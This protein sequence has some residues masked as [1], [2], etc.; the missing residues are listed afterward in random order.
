MITM[1]PALKATPRA[2]EAAGECSATCAHAKRRAAAASAQAALALVGVLLSAGR[3]AAPKQNAL[4]STSTVP[5]PHMIQSG[6]S[7]AR[8]CFAPTP[9]AS[10]ARPV[11]THA[12]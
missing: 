10:A 12:A 2:G 8:S 4:N 6:T 1:V 3:A 11:R 5:A 7:P 9:L